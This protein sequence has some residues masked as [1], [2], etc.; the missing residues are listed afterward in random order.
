VTPEELAAEEARKKAEAEAAAA[1]RHDCEDGAE[2][3]RLKRHIDDRFAQLEG[4]L[5]APAP[6]PAPEPKGE[7]SI[8]AVVL[9]VVGVLV[10]VGYFVR[11]K[12]ASST[13]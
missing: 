1:H 7:G 10:A 13:P 5:A 6:K 9:V 8:V 12:L 2:H 11:K 4:R 3:A